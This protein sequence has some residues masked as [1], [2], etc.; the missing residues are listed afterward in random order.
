LQVA[1]IIP[2]VYS[3]GY[4]A[5]EAK[6][7]AE[8][9]LLLIEQ[10]EA[11]GEPP[12]DPLLLFSALY[13]FWVP[14]YAAF[15]GDVV[16]EL[17]AQFLTLA[18]KQRATIPLMIGHRLMGVSLT[19]T[20]NVTQGRAHFDQALALYDPTEHRPLATQFG[21]DVRVAILSYRSL[22]LWVL[23]YP[24][25]ALADGDRALKYAREIGQVA[26][27]MYALF[28]TSFALVHCGSYQTAT[29]RL[30]ELVA[31]AREKNAE[32]WTGNAMMNQGAVLALTGKAS[33]AIRVIISGITVLQ[34]MGATVHI[35][36]PLSCLAAASTDL[37]QFDDA[38]RYIDEGITALERTKENVWEAEIHRT[39]GE[40]VLKSPERDAMKA[41][42]YLSA[43]SRSPANNKQN[44]GN[45]APQ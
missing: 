25:A 13:G 43:L 23:G 6:A 42:A 22:A 12:D 15:N 21:Q 2:L 33:D 44:P 27:L 7:A 16:C 37:G 29:T 20:G 14:N 18:K 31:V 34:S 11:L 36:F 32:N 41:Q 38:W 3:K 28:F 45:S 24:D 39:A 30:D 9:S 1:L 5:P 40:I 4:G 10:A 17:A 35:P 19:A 8:R 26:A